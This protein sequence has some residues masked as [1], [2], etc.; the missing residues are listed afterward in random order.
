MT[1]IIPWI[2]LAI[3]YWLYLRNNFKLGY[4]ETKLDNASINISKVKNMPLYKLWLD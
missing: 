1:Y 4:Y 3:I 2:L